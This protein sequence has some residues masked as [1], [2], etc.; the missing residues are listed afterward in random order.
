[1]TACGGV[2]N[3]QAVPIKPFQSFKT[4]SAVALGAMSEQTFPSEGNGFLL[5]SRHRSAVILTSI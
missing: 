4:D 3:I 2:E 1:V 5:L